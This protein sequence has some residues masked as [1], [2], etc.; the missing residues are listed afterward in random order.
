MLDRFDFAAN[1][2]IVVE[3][4]TSATAAYCEVLGSI[5]RSSTTSGLDLT[6]IT[7]D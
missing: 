6:L 3:V 4:V 2:V 5:N 1:D 7:R